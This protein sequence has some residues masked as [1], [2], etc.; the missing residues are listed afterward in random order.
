MGFLLVLCF[1]LHKLSTL[2]H[3]LRQLCDE[4]GGAYI[5]E[6]SLLSNVGKKKKKERK[7]EKKKEESRV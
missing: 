2:L 7:R 3:L 1:V 6:K 5:T 4:E